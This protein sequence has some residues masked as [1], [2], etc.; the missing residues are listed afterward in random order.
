MLARIKNDIAIASAILM[1][2]SGIVMCFLAFFMEVGEHVADNALWYMG[3]ALIYASGIFGIKEYVDMKI[4]QHS[5]KFG[6][7]E[8]QNHN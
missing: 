3:E 1:L 7:N 6:S 4:G 8:T 2:L 5:I